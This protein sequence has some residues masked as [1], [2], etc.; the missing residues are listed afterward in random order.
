MQFI[1]LLNQYLK[2]YQNYEKSRNYI[3]MDVLQL[4]MM[5]ETPQQIRAYYTK[6]ADKTGYN[7][8]ELEQVNKIVNQIEQIST[9]TSALYHLDLPDEVLPQ[10]LDW[11]KPVP[12]AVLTKIN[13]RINDSDLRRKER[14]EKFIASKSLAFRKGM[15]PT[16]DD[17]ANIERQNGVLDINSWK[18]IETHI[19]YNYNNKGSVLYSQLS[20]YL[21]SDQAAS[22]YLASIGIPG[23]K[24]FDQAS[25]KKGEGTHNYVIWDQDVLDR[26]VL[27]K[28]NSERLQIIKETQQAYNLQGELEND[29][30]TYSDN[31]STASGK[32]VRPGGREGAGISTLGKAITDELVTKGRIDLRGRTVKTADE[33]ATM[34]QVFRDPR[35]ETMRY[36]YVDDNGKIL[37]HEG[38]SSRMPGYSQTFVTDRARAVQDM[39]E[40]MERLGATGYWMLHNHP[41]G[42]P[43]PSQ[44]D[45]DVTRILAKEVPGFKGHVVINSGKYSFIQPQNF[46]NYIYNL[47]N[48]PSDWVDPLLT[49]G[50]EHAALGKAIKTPSDLAR[51]GQSLKRPENYTSL[52]FR[53]VDGSV[54]T[55]QN[56]PNGMLKNI[57]QASGYLRNRTAEFG[58]PEIFAYTD[59][60]DRDLHVALQNLFA[61]GSLRDVIHKEHGRS[62]LEAGA[63][64]ASDLQF[65]RQPRGVGFRVAEESF[66]EYKPTESEN[67]AKEHLN[68]IVR[69]ITIDKGGY[70][71][72]KPSAEIPQKDWSSTKAKSW[73][74]N[75]T[76]LLIQEAVYQ[77]SPKV[78][79]M[80][81]LKKFLT[82]PE[83][84]EHPVFS[85]IVRLFIRD[86][87]EIRHEV[88]AHLNNLE[89]P[90]MEENTVRELALK[91]K[92]KG[93]S[94]T[95][96]AAGKSSQEYEDLKRIIDEADI[97]NK[98]YSEDDLKKQGYSADTI[99]VWKA[100]RESYDKALDIL[101]TN[102]RDMI[103]KIEEEAA[104]K[105]IKPVDYSELYMTLKG[106]LASM[107]QYR[108]S[109][110]PRVRQGDWAVTA[111]RGEG[112][113]V[114]YYREHRNSHYA[115]AAL[116]RQL[117]ASGWHIRYVGEVQ[118]LPEDI[119][120]D[121][122]TVSVAKAIE[123]A[124]D[125]MEKE[126]PTDE[127][128]PTL[129]FKEE[130]LR[131]VADL[132]RARGFRSSMIHRKSELPVVRGYIEDPIQRHA[133][134]TSNI[135]AGVAKSRV[136]SAAINELNGEWVKGVKVGGI[137]PK[138]EPEIYTAA[139]DYIEEQLRNL[140]RIDRLIGWGKS[141]ATL[142]FLGFSARGAF[143]NLTAIVTTAPPAIQQYA[144]EGKAS[145]TAVNKALVLA[146]KD[147]IQFMTTGK[148]TGTEDENHFL[149]EERRR[150]WDDPQ[151]TRD[152]ISKIDTSGNRAWATTLDVSM[153]M[154]GKSEQWNRI[155]TMLAA[156]RLA[157]TNGKNHTEAAELAK[158]ATDKAHGIYGRETL[159]AIAWGRNPTAKIAQ[160]LYTF[161]KFGH[162]YLQLLNDLGFRKTIGKPFRMPFLHR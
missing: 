129:K 122:K 59:S 5:N 124:V 103:T 6:F 32:V 100:Y 46:I 146:G 77:L 141:L 110:A 85:R 121:L 44:A 29:F 37:A 9:T 47:P 68:S 26:I 21:G 138:T 158:T 52:I 14:Y 140:D 105:G 80:G 45:I 88:F 145:L 38:I 22:E 155:T 83:W 104:F 78:H 95:E 153:W 76:D 89:Q 94:L 127:R 144:T 149:L 118:K 81:L 132:I 96:R 152:M 18:E 58:A 107:G 90:Q 20:E 139:R 109:Y 108:G 4:A 56:I 12:K 99:A 84:Y 93:L 7:E 148:I 33:L 91:L 106:A 66:E 102:M 133:I 15:T 101:M 53:G 160:M 24:Y 97:N 55:I 111:T 60:S 10:L 54:R 120:Q 34:A 162:N 41:S 114:E 71:K 8:A 112:K 72:A 73:I 28:R 128:T 31:L 123:T 57:E 50:K 75:E 25:R 154:F 64:R 74:R 23:L 137:N 87:N 159:P 70:T 39:K 67:K 11:D 27:L 161:S 3:A 17:F 86:R 42:R 143:V 40:R 157:R 125:N 30:E 69:K 49:V 13:N 119:Y 51:I 151:Y 150:G 92:H 98:I 48:L 117:R 43:S 134:Y 116:A 113:N 135:A 65:G 2:L 61:N 1:I 19:S 62:Y 16:I 82:S 130:I 79:K 63:P 136:A 142:K 126:R 156:Y 36:F 147:T 35:I 131:Q 115:V